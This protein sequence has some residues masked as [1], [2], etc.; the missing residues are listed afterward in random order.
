MEHIVTAR[1]MVE[2]AIVV[3]VVLATGPAVVAEV[4]VGHTI[5]VL[6][7][8]PVAVVAGVLVDR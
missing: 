2:L 7:T 6:A 8:G 1:N 3:L 4:L 5:V